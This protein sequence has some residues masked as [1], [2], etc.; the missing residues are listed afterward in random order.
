MGKADGQLPTYLVYE[1]GVIR[2]K[3]V[4]DPRITGVYWLKL[5]NFIAKQYKAKVE[6]LKEATIFKVE[7]VMAN[8]IIGFNIESG[9]LEKIKTY[10]A[11]IKASNA[12][13][14]EKTN[15]LHYGKII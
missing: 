6:L 13:L 1:N 7:H 8:D 11:R 9:D 2:F 10:Q 5:C 14:P 15:I 4:S 12:S 3:L